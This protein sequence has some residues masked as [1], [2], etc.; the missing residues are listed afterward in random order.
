MFRPATVLRPLKAPTKLLTTAQSKAA[1]ILA[2]RCLATTS[3]STTSPSP[4]E[5]PFTPTPTVTTTT[6]QPLAK[7]E[8]PSASASASPQFQT[9]Q[10]Q[11]QQHNPDLL[12]KQQ[13]QPLLLPY[14]VGRTPSSNFAVYELAKRGGN[15]LLTAIKKVEGDRAA[16]RAELSRGLGLAEVDAKGKKTVWVNTLT[17]HVIVAGHRKSQV[18]EWLEKLGF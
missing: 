11:Q 3:T 16:F 17:G 6:T 9:Q 5:P 13:P 10:Q 8:G 1:I 15:K 12:P 14:R 7:A 4:P 2:R 18:V